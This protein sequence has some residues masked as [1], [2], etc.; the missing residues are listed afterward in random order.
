MRPR[1]A[2]TALLVSAALLLGQGG[3]VARSVT[4]AFSEEGLRLELAADRAVYRVGE[5]VELTLAATNSG[6]A[7]VTLTAP[8]SQLY[9]FAILND[10]GAVWRW[11]RGR[12]FLTVLTPLTIRPGE[13]RTFKEKW[14][15]RDQSGRQVGP[16]DYVV[17]G[18]LIG[19]KEA[20]LG[21]ERFRI[22]IR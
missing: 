10:S 3:P 16:G 2:L 6:S 12:M 18:L 13:V 1:G 4:A 20:G 8:S 11:S 7:P 21:P 22:T 19:G 9:D 5:P 17:E 15:Q 14:D